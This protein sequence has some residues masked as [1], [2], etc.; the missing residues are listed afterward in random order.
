MTFEPSPASKLP[1]PRVDKV[2]IFNLFFSLSFSKYFQALLRTLSDVGTAITNLLP[3][4]REA[5]PLR[6]TFQLNVYVTYKD[7]NQSLDANDTFPCLDFSDITHH[8][9]IGTFQ[10]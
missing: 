3:A 1:V 6:E 10:C 8:Q 5:Q 4:K 7:V 2:L 9:S